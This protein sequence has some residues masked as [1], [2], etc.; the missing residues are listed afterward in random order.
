MLVT[1][2]LKV[3]AK[4]LMNLGGFIKK[5]EFLSSTIAQPNYFVSLQFSSFI[6]EFVLRTFVEVS[7]CGN[8]MHRSCSFSAC[9]APNSVNDIR[10]PVVPR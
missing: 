6:M 8:E 2:G 9:L 1:A 4:A 5:L 3:L 10:E 7:L